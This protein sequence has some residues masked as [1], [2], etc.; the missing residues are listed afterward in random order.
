MVASVLKSEG[1]KATIKIHVLITNGASVNDDSAINRQIAK[2]TD[3]LDNRAASNICFGFLL[4]PWLCGVNKLLTKP[5]NLTANSGA[6]FTL[7]P[8]IALYMC[9]CHQ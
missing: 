1:E 6:S 4:I 2:C 3:S 8:P 5:M 9:G 7:S